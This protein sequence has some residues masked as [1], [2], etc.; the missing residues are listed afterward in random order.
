MWDGVKVGT[1][2]FLLAVQ[3][4][5]QYVVSGLENNVNMLLDIETCKM[6]LGKQCATVTPLLSLV[7]P[8]MKTGIFV[9]IC[10][11]SH[12]VVNGNWENEW[13]KQYVG[14]SK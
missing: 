13:H 6:Q 9:T 4:Q 7:Y 2:N 10:D 1:D 12:N 8:G 3:Y 11:L 14:N 5:I